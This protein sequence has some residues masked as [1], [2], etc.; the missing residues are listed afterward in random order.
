MRKGRLIRALRSPPKL[1][2]TLSL[3]AGTFRQV[4]QTKP[5]PATPY[6]TSSIKNRAPMPGFRDNTLTPAQ[7]ADG[8]PQFLCDRAFHEKLP[9]PD[10]GA[11]LPLETVQFLGPRVPF[12]PEFQARRE[13]LARSKTLGSLYL[14]VD[15]ERGRV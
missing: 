10:S 4:E 14:H 2:F 7:T 6:S 13:C 11:L 1:E 9:Q 8:I 5:H 12:E 15:Q 3:E